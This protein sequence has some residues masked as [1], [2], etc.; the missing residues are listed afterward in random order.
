[1]RTVYDSPLPALKHLKVKTAGS[2][3]SRVADL[4]DALSWVSPSLETLSMEQS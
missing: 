4:E 1:M 3:S 2:P